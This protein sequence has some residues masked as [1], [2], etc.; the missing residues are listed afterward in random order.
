MGQLRWL[1]WACP[2][3]SVD[4]KQHWT[5]LRHWSQFV[6][7]MSTDMRR[8]EA[9]L[10]HHCGTK[11]K[12]DRPYLHVIVNSI[13]PPSPISSYNTKKPNRQSLPASLQLSTLSYCSLTDSS[14]SLTKRSQI[15]LTCRNVNRGTSF[16]AWGIELKRF[17]R[18]WDICGEWS[19]GVEQEGA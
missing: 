11:V 18:D 5:V 14:L 6:S 2:T 16:L 7:N 12:L 9:L 19:G 10:Y 17:V 15:R 13:T 3:V 8:H 1:S 4:V